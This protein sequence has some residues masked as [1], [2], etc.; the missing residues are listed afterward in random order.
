MV[1]Y[2]A[3]QLGV[4]DTALETVLS[5]TTSLCSNLKHSLKEA[6][7]NLLSWTLNNAGQGV[8]GLMGGNRRDLY[9]VRDQVTGFIF[10][11]NNTRLGRPY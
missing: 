4:A 6:V 11:L 8:D 1:A 10:P 3:F 5:H 7:Q 2:S 9:I